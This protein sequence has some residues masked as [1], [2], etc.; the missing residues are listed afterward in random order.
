[1]ISPILKF[2]STALELI[3]AILRLLDYRSS[4]TDLQVDGNRYQIGRIKASNK[5]SLVVL[6]LIFFCTGLLLLVSF[7]QT[8]KNNPLTPDKNSSIN[9]IINNA[10]ND[11]VWGLPLHKDKKIMTWE[12]ANHFARNGHDSHGN[13]D[14]TLPTA[15]KLELFAQTLI[16]QPVKNFL[17]GFYW[18]NTPQQACNPWSGESRNE[19]PAHA[20][21]WHVVLSR[22]TN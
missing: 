6:S 22:K 7:S 16:D 5:K 4:K 8:T 21:R 1:M 14:W 19:P 18:T 12:E 11:L 13:Q 3:L 9:I 10:K 17:K 20:S 15:V 2:L